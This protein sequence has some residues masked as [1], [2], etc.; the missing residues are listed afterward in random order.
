MG[1][2]IFVRTDTPDFTECSVPFHTLDEMVHICRTPPLNAIVDKIIVCGEA[3][4]GPCTL[5]MT[6]VSLC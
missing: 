5:T 3:H 2:V 1:K 4:G 6:F